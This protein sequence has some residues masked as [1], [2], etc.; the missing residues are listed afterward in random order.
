MSIQPFSDHPGA[1]DSI[2]PIQPRDQR[3]IFDVPNPLTSLIGREE[4]VAMLVERLQQPGVRL[5]TLCGPGGTG[6]TRLAIAAANRVAG[7]FQR[8]QFIPLANTTDADHVPVAIARATG[9]REIGR[10]PVEQAIADRL[11]DRPSLL[12]L[13]NLEQVI[14][15]ATFI[16]ALL[17]ACPSLTILA[18]SRISLH[19]SGEHEV[20]VLPLAVPNMTEA[21]LTEN[22]AVA[23]FIDRVQAF[24]SGFSP[25][26]RAL[27]AIAEICRR[28][29]GLPLAIELA[30]ARVKILPPEALLQRLDRQLD[31][32]TGGPRDSPPHQRTMRDTIAWS[33]EL[34]DEREQH[35][36]R[37]LSIFPAGV[38]LT[39]AERLA[40]S[41]DTAAIDLLSS[42][43]EKSLLRTA[44]D[45]GGTPRFW[46]LATLR[47]FGAECLEAL[48]ELT[49]AH[50]QQ[51]SLM[52][53]LVS[54]HSR[55]LTG[56]NQERALK[57]LDREDRNLVAALS[58]LRESEETERFVTLAASL[59]RY[60]HMRGRYREG[61]LWL[62]RAVNAMTGKH[63]P[64]SL[65][66]S[67]LHGAGWLA[68]GLGDSTSA[69]SQALAS[70]EQARS[71]GDRTG[72][73]LA[74]GL[75]AA[76]HYRAT[77]YGKSRVLFEQALAIYREIGDTAGAATT[78][79]RL[80]QAEMDDGH[81]ERAQELFIESRR[82]F[83]LCGNQHGAALAIDNLS[84]IRYSQNRN[85]EA[86]ALAEQALAILRQFDDWRS[87]AVALGHIGKC[88]SRRLDLARSWEA[89]RE[90]L[91]LRYEVGDRRGL[92]VWLEAVAYLLVA[93]RRFEAA[94]EAIGATQALR[95]LVN[96]PLFGNELLDQQRALAEI[97][98]DIGARA[99]ATALERGSADSLETAI[100]KGIAA[101]EAALVGTPGFA[102][103]NPLAE[104]GLSE[105][106]LDVLELMVQRLSD[107][108]IA[109]RLFISPRTVGRHA[110]NIYA[111]LN[112]RNRREAAAF[113]A[114]HFERPGAIT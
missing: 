112:V 49:A 35:L 99:T 76:V 3:A 84:I 34:L 43:V 11:L 71:A 27:G 30:A 68:L 5:V 88:A 29:D 114:P 36:F 91:A 40:S 107:R 14:A 80:G 8:V 105:R 1:P 21:N 48:G 10:T 57:S 86:E 66:A 42:L 103:T 16:A 65:Q 13:D 17:A 89:H 28:L 74:L 56:I 44:D 93:A 87:M 97:S 61:W 4:E 72:E 78:L 59:Q 77:E 75:Q 38:T 45:R 92:A 18:T 41:P 55:D 109:E 12:I 96:T 46:M 64:A 58:F 2:T 62:D 70:L 32:L 111:K 82:S 79:F 22:E 9:V 24:Q 113:A 60:W 106:E 83:E 104:I 85:E 19:I 94:A 20:H 90:G 37:N 47:E 102:A 95:L 53:D 81:F 73:A 54:L 6:K 25:A 23:L 98:S 33:Y 31:V 39:T 7:A 67:A 69:R 101:V 63:I 108:E 52:I 26:E 50:Q 51:A 110:N 100:A 15:S